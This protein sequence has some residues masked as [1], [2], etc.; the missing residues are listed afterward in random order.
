VNRG[1]PI[2][3][4]GLFGSPESVGFAGLLSSAELVGFAG[5][6]RSAESLGFT[7][8]VNPVTRSFVRGYRANR[9]FANIIITF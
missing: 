3:F 7:G 2:G 5:L 4:A 8:L 6:F 1:E 9:I